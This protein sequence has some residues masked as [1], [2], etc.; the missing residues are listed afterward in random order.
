MMI[1]IKNKILYFFQ[2]LV[3]SANYIFNKDFNERKIIKQYV[4]NNGIVFDVG[5]NIGS[6]F[7]FVSKS[8]KGRNIQIHSFEPGVKSCE[9]QKNL[10]IPRNYKLFINNLAVLDGESREVKFYERS[11]SSHSSTLSEP[12]MSAI[13]G[14]LDSYY[15]KTVSID[16]YC[17]DNNISFIDLLKVDAEGVDFEVLKSCENMLKNKKI[18][19][20]KT[21]VWVNKETPS[22][23]FQYLLKFD[24]KLL[25]ITNLSYLDNELKFF[26]AYFAVSK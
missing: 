19:L 21:E 22:L 7:K 6:F 4:Q 25:G 26:D 8:L 12:Q 23:I 1:L 9:F 17:Q 3:I 15:V 2:L 24:Y 11:I 20:I 10:K 14:E 18:K 5:S 13:S 16:K